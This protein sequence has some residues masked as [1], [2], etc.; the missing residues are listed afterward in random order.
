M[1][2]E[3]VL[4]WRSA[5]NMVVF[6]RVY[7]LS[8]ASRKCPFAKWTIFS[9]FLLASAQSFALIFLG[10]AFHQLAKVHAAA[11]TDSELHIMAALN[12]Q[13]R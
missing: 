5:V 8:D 6:R 12:W 3:R 2:K 13:V 7:V 1:S 11:L 10:H 4:H 9:A